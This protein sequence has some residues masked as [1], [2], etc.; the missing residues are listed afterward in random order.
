[1]S[2]VRVPD[3]YEP[4]K[5]KEPREYYNRHA[6]KALPDAIY[7]EQQKGTR[8]IARMNYQKRNIQPPHME[9]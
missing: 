4:N 9:E 5:N 6:R 8:G 2:I 7:Q 1:M 3:D